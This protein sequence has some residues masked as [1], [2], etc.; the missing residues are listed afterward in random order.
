MIDAEM[1][2]I[3]RCPA[4]GGQ[5][6]LAGERLVQRV[7]EAISR[8]EARD[9]VDQAVTTPIEGG[10]LPTSCAFLYPIRGGIPS[11]VREDAIELPVD[12]E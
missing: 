2:A 8:G 3:L 1:L 5:L 6:Q 10:L 7:N 12:P 11:L 4:E 9:R